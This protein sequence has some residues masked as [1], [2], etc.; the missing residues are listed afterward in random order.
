MKLQFLGVGSQYSSHDL[1]HSNIL[2]TATSG[3]RLLIDCG[4][5][6]HF[7]LAERHIE[8]ADIDAVYISHLHSD[9]VGGL[10]RLALT[11]YFDKGKNPRPKLFG[12]VQML[13]RLWQHTLK[14]G[15]ECIG[16]RLMTLNDYFDCRPISE[17]GSFIWEDARFE[18]IK[19]PHISG[20]ACRLFSYGLR[21]VPQGKDNNAIFFS[22]DSVFQPETLNDIAPR[23]ALIFHD[24]ETAQAHS[25]VHA[26]YD[27][28]KTL[29]EN[30]KQKTWLYHYQPN[31]TYEPVHDGFRGFVIKGQEFTL[32]GD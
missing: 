9:H 7:S 31:P 14:G 20:P 6:A 12:E 3:H 13:D 29:P 26:H 25:Q 1:Y 2:I 5:D 4:T 17:N 16:S 18:L 28:L 11:R 27:E 32:I 30:I 23:V 21:I 24:C 15:L 22:S 19:M 10:E 8:P